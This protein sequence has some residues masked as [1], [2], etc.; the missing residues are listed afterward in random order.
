MEVICIGSVAQVSHWWPQELTF[1]VLPSALPSPTGSVLHPKPQGVPLLSSQNVIDVD[2]S[3]PPPSLQETFN[4]GGA[5]EMLN[6]ETTLSG[7]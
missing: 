2:D 3:P 4:H 5:E 6:G 1:T 7:Y